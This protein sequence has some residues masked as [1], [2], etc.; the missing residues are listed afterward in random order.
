MNVETD[1]VPPVPR[2]TPPIDEKDIQK[3][4]RIDWQQWFE[5][6]RA[7][8][9]VIDKTLAS[10][11]QLVGG[12]IVVVDNGTA[13][14]R[15][16]TGTPNR[17]TVAN[18]DGVLGNPTIDVVTDDLI[19]GDD[20]SF[21]GSGADRVIDNGSGPLTINYDGPKLPPGGTTGQ[22]LVKLSNADYDVGWVDP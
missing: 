21:G 11:G 14:P 22:I 2:H 3:R 5:I 10:I 16:I 18:G 12:G 4:F 9:N 17:V 19:P 20:I 8:V 1:Q 7:K 13:I 6:L 15:A